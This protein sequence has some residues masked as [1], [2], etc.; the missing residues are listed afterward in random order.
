[1]MTA[2][3]TA[4][5]QHG[6]MA[7]ADKTAHGQQ[8]RDDDCRHDH[9]WTAG[10]WWQLQ[11]CP[12]MGRRDVMTAAGMNTLGNRIE[13]AAHFITPFINNLRTYRVIL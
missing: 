11:V 3:M 7:A 4:H 13:L 12:Y 1:M 8:G 6:V 9:K 5:G 2:D 10:A